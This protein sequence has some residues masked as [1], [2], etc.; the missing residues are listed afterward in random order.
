VL[1]RPVLGVAGGYD[2]ELQRKSY[3]GQ[4]YELD[5]LKTTLAVATCKYVDAKLGFQECR[6]SVEKDSFFV[7]LRLVL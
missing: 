5:S 7:T 4:K 1:L 6:G 2:L 3:P